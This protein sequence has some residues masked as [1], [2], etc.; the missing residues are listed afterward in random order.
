MCSPIVE[1]KA[2]LVCIPICNRWSSCISELSL[3]KSSSLIF[4]TAGILEC[5]FLCTQ[6]AFVTIFSIFQRFDLS[7][8]EFTVPPV[9]VIE[10]PS[11]TQDS[12]SG[13]LG[14][15]P[16]YTVSFSKNFHLFTISSKAINPGLLRLYYMTGAFFYCNPMLT[17]FFVFNRYDLS[18]NEIIPPRITEAFLCSSFILGQIF[19]SQNLQYLTGCSK[20]RVHLSF[21]IQCQ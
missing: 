12:D 14:W 15:I 11:S 1:G 2:S 19:Y 20:H 16:V 8:T 10:K 7:Q 17:A 6:S 3:K 21:Q 18:Q 13:I 5:G 9:G 4:S